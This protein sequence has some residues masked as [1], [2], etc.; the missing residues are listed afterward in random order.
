MFKAL[1]N[2]SSSSLQ[3]LC[4]VVLASNR[5]CVCV[6]CVH[7]LITNKPGCANIEVIFMRRILCINKLSK[8]DGAGVNGLLVDELL[9]L[10]LFWHNFLFISWSGHSII[11]PTLSQNKSPHL[12]EFLSLWNRLKTTA[13]GLDCG[14]GCF[15]IILCHNPCVKAV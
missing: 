10:L 4:I 14:C 3:K 6:L 11:F 7:Q 12:N 1:W 5:L 9:L 15:L 8:S 13:P 2:I